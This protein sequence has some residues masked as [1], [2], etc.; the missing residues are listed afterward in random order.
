MIQMFDLNRHVRILERCNSTNLY[1]Y[2]CHRLSMYMY[3]YRRRCRIRIRSLSA[4][5]RYLKQEVYEFLESYLMRGNPYENRALRTGYP[6]NHKSSVRFCCEF[7]L[8]SPVFIVI[9]ELPHPSHVVNFSSVDDSCMILSTCT[10][11]ALQRSPRN[12]IPLQDSLY[13]LIST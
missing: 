13:V 7:A 12:A 5:F 2:R 3:R 9:V 10:E 6:I 8:L 4:I 1:I 11:S